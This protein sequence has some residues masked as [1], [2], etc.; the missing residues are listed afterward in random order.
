[1]H[2]RV[3]QLLAASA[4]L[5]A[6]LQAQPVISQNGVYNS[7]SYRQA[8]LPG[9]GI[10]QGSIFSIFGTGLG[11]GAWTAAESF[12]LPTKLNGTS[13]T[14][15]MGSTQT[16]AI[17][18]GADA[19]QINAILPSPT[20]TGTGTITV[21]YQG[22]TSAPQPVQV[23][24]SA[25]GIFAYNEGGAGQAIATD[26][27]YELNTIIHP[28]HTGD[29]VTLWGTGLGP[30]KGSD[31]EPPPAG[32]LPTPVT[33]HVGNTT[34]SVSYSGRAPCCAGLDQIVFQLPAGL[35]GC[36][37]PIGIE[38]GGVTGNIET[39]AIASSGQATCSDSILGQD[40]V[41]KVASGESVDF[42]YI[43]LESAITTLYADFAAPFQGD[44]AMATFSQ[45]DPAQAGL[46]EYGV[47][48]GYCYATSNF[49]SLD[50]SLSDFSPAQLNAGNL[51]FQSAQPM[52]LNESSPGSGYYYDYLSGYGRVL[53]SGESYMVSGSGAPAVGPFSV[54]DTTEVNG[55]K[56]TN[57]QQANQVVPRSSDFVVEWTGGNSALQ[58]GQ[59]TILG[60]SLTGIT[61][62][63]VASVQCTAPLSAQQLTIPGW[64][65]S[66]LP[67]SGIYAEGTLDIPLGFLFIG[68]Y[69]TPTEFSAKGLD[70]GIITDIL[71]YGGAV[72]FQ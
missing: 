60:L 72:T 53:W 11:G 29:Y 10:A 9:S 65:L 30:I 40:L 21:T 64:V 33:V 66:S 43:R 34:A 57:I 5:A 3:I 56:F 31:A 42:G 67:P 68:Q 51:T 2:S 4:F 23:V 48:S 13:A 16:S 32:S 50:G 12:P 69:N 14:I 54:T 15:T 8:G 17:I 47:S 70:R 1:M 61:N 62:P 49:G 59:V 18:L 6:A 20:P 22:Q 44:Y 41:S 45:I 58:N 52:Q 28:F 19:F 55:L 24:S 46:A 26:V 7:A 35:E 38:T 39:I 71:F 25:F 27:N 36:Y 37:V 63:L